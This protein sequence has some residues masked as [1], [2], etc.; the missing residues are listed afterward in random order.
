MEMVQSRGERKD[1]WK[2]SGGIIITTQ[3][4][5]CLRR[6]RKLGCV[7]VCERESKPWRVFLVAKGRRINSSSAAPITHSN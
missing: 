5:V 7:S 4:S 1:S 3:Q 2:E 6:D